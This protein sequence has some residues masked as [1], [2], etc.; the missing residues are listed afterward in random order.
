MPI[1]VEEAEDSPFLS[2]MIQQDKKFWQQYSRM[3]NAR[4]EYEKSV[5]AL[6]MRIDLK[7]E[8]EYFPILQKLQENDDSMIH[9]TK[10][11]L[12]KY[13]RYTEGIGQDFTR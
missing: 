4:S 6:N 11:S 9:F 13:A 8:S 7:V 2:L 3:E 5:A 12:E 10:N 1:I